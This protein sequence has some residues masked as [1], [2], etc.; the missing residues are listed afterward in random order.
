MTQFAFLAPEFPDLLAHAQKAETAALSDPRGACFYARL[1]LETALNWLFR[2]ESAL[3]RPYGRELAALIAEPSLLAL[4]G[5]AIVTKAKYIKDQGNRAAHDS[6]KPISPQDAAAT[7]REL[8]HVCYWIARTY[9]KGA[10]PDPASSFDLAKLEPTLTIT[11]ST[12]TQIKEQAAAFA[13]ARK[14]LEAAEDARRASDEGRAALEAELAALRAQVAAA[15]RANQAVPDPHDY[16]E[17]A[18]RDAFIDLLLMEAGWPLDQ[19]RDREF[20]VQGMPNQSGDGFVDYV[21]WGDDGKPL[22]VVEAKRTKKDSR[23]G[24]NQARLYADCLEA[25]YG[26]RPVIFTTNGYEHWLWDDK[27]YPPRPVSGFL[28]KDELV[29]LHQRRE[30]RKKLDDVAIDE[31]IAGRFYQQRAIR[32]VGE[33]FEKDMLR[34]SLLVMAT[35]SGKTRTVIALVDQ[36]QRANWVKRVLFLADRVALVK[37]AHG[38]FKTHLPATPCANLLERNDPQKNDHAGAKVLFSTYPT[39]MGMIDEVKNGQKNFG[40]GHFDLIVIDEA[41]R[42]IYKKYRA[43]F[44]Y[45]DGMLIGLTATPRDEI[46][47]DTY[48]L[49]ELERGVPTDAYDLDDAVADGFLVPPRSISVPLKF[50]RDG[51]AYDQLSEEEKEEWDAIEWD[52]EGNVPDRVESADLHKWL[53]NI[54][55]VDKVLE[56]VM[57]KGIKV[58]GGD[59]L[60]KTIIFAKNSAHA[61]FI[62]D[63]FNANY[64]HY[65]GKFAQLIDYSVTYAQSLIDDFSEVE[66]PP[67]IAVSVDMLDTGIDIPEVVNLVFFKIARSKTK[68]WQMVGRGTRLCPNLFGPNED[69]EEFL[70]FDFCQ[71]L[72]FFRENPRAIDGPLARPIGERLFST[73]VDLIGE[74]Q[75]LSEDHGEL[76][77]SLKSRLLDEV[78]GMNLDNFI[79]RAKRR[80]VETFQDDKNWAALDLDA[81]I[82]L[83]TD[84][85][86]LPSAYQDDAL[87]AKQFDLLILNA[88]L[89]LLRGESGF[90][91][92]QA[93]IIRFASALERL[94]NVPAVARELELILEIQTD[95]FWKDITVDILEI[96]RKRLRML[97]DLIQPIER[98]VVITDFEDE[99][100]SG[101]TVDLPEIGGG[102]DKAR[103]KLKMRRFIEVHADHLA[104]QKIRR[105]IPITPQDLT[106]LEAMMLGDGAAD[107]GVLATIRSSGGLGLFLRQLVGLDRAAAKDAFSEFVTA[108]KLNANQTE[109]INLII[110]CLT[111]TGTIEP[112][113]FYESPFTDISAQGITGVFSREQGSDIIRIV[114][115]LNTVAAA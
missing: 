73:R 19:P 39:M 107:A 95:D 43:I 115:Q 18:T 38:A 113:L 58:A 112:G 78:R 33:A 30:T 54:D 100:G 110:D 61:H 7:V 70:I 104:L 36:L 106:E 27:M 28:K 29:L 109:F 51:I 80:A 15:R 108:Q 35:G 42:S 66:K 62:V 91:A 12:V 26:R 17:A 37:Q 63:R 76:L 65:H 25:A 68:F 102:V 48:S 84:I 2:R 114:T 44:D 71:N 24:Q 9:A 41:H 69:K 87:P 79:V 20:A 16:D 85:A 88:Q 53:F 45:F 14:A 103:F 92:L 4:T 105:A 83:Q 94:A 10:K 23:I 74:L 22:A 50:Q 86:G 77:D 52:E 96:I 1:T 13:A 101:D 11:A 55:T 49:F 46:D 72:E 64:P 99:I 34:K 81:R 6:G 3:K 32:R 59:R 57:R 98:K 89:C 75:N 5:P 90:A 82:T 40:P 31:A 47:R 111:E 67:H 56:H 8:F 21:L 93:R 97:V 60:G